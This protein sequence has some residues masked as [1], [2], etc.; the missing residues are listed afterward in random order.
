MWIIAEEGKDYPAA[1]GVKYEVVDGIRVAKVE[2]PDTA[3]IEQ[4]ED[5][6]KAKKG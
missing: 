3:E 1:T 4:K 2:V 5:K 6:P